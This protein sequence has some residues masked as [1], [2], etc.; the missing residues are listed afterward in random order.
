MKMKTRLQFATTLL[1]MTLL[2][3]P[4]LA[5]G[6]FEKLFGSDSSD[7]SSFNELI[8]HVPAD[9]SFLFTN[10]KAIPEAVMDFHLK[11]S[12]KLF[13]LVSEQSDKSKKDDTKNSPEAFFSAF[14]EDLSD[15]F[16]NKKLEETGLSLSSNYIIYGV[17]MTPVMRLSITDKE[18]LMATLKR[19]EEKSGYKLDLSKC[20]DFDCMLDNTN[21]DRSMALV[22][23]KNQL[24]ASVFAVD[25]KEQMINHLTGKIPAKDAYKAESWETFLKD[26]FYTG[27]GEG[28]IDLQK[29]YKKGSPLIVS[30]LQ[31]DKRLSDDE[32]KNCMGVAADHINNMPKVIFGTKGLNAQKMDYEF[33][34]TTSAGVSEVLQGIANKANIAQRVDNAI[35]DFGLN[36]NFIKL[37]EALTQY[38][39]FLI[40]SAETH[41]CKNIKAADIRKGMGGM[42]MA[43]NMGLTQFKSLYVAVNDVE[44]DSRMQPKKIDAYVSIGADDPAGLLGMVSMLSPALMGFKVPADGT[45]VKLPEGAIP[46]KGLP[47]PPISI[48]RTENTLNLMVGNDKPALKKYLSGVPAIMIMG[49]N[50]KRY[51]EKLSSIMKPM[52][53]K[54]SD[55]TIINMM[56]SIGDTAGNVQQEITADKRG[57]AFNYHI[58]YEDVKKKSEQ[59]SK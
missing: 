10:K 46:T 34:L 12:Q 7:S 52:A 6:F 44:L 3:S 19:A 22:L 41:K 59:A 21:K 11:R 37:R 56:S 45:V 9:T 58:Q 28:F 4:V 27:H 1:T 15:K 54:S 50:S 13:K 40:K 5:E 33:V 32:L 17:D 25:K 38:S 48:S 55:Q 16:A 31:K 42:M 47:V 36:I 29:L 26:N 8:S 57:L 18:K 14:F 2:G 30:E 53:G 20:G 43:M 23:L 51:Y 49:I 39:E 35:V 24:V